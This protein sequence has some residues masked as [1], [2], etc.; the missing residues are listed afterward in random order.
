M[1]EPSL[2]NERWGFSTNLISRFLQVKRARVSLKN[3]W[4]QAK[5][6]WLRWSHWNGNA[7]MKIIP[8]QLWFGWGIFGTK[9]DFRK[10]RRHRRGRGGKLEWELNWT[11]NKNHPSYP[12][13]WRGNLLSCIYYVSYLSIHP[14]PPISTVILEDL[15]SQTWL[16]FPFVRLTMLFKTWS[17][18]SPPVQREGDRLGVRG[19][20]RSPQERGRSKHPVKWTQYARNS[21]HLVHLNERQVIGVSMLGLVRPVVGVNDHFSNLDLLKIQISTFISRSLPDLF[22]SLRLSFMGWAKG[23]INPSHQKR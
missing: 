21:F 14:F 10:E 22:S 17:F 13:P 23:H 19:S 11:P 5:F 16:L 4:R 1:A 8:T 7:T 15:E 6:G 3:Y 2:G 18:S 20:H 12:R 9:K